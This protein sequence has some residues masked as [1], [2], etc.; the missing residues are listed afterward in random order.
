MD[1]IL[2]TLTLMIWTVNI[3]LFLAGILIGGL[4]T[5]SMAP[6]TYRLYRRWSLR[7]DWRRDRPRRVM[8]SLTPQWEPYDPGLTGVG[9]R[10]ICHRRQIHPGERVLL[11]PETGPMGILHVAVYCPTVKEHV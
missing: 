8:E 5:L 10:C 4:G 9:R 3:S 6:A 2:F 7:R 11:W 1:G